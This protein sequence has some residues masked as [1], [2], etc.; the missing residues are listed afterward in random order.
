MI[1]VLIPIIAIALFSGCSREKIIFNKET[2]RWEKII[3][4]P[5]VVNH[6]F[7]NFGVDPTNDHLK[8]YGYIKSDIPD[9]N[10][11]LGIFPIYEARK[12]LIES[13]KNDKS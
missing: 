3:E 2:M 13:M 8:K 7:Y 5:K 10:N 1:K 9:F 4:A 12:Q 11:E 6:D